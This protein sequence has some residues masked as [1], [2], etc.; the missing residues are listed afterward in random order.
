M[1]ASLWWLCLG[2][3]AIGTEGFMIAGLL[4]V[5]AADLGVSVPAA[6][7]LVTVFAITYAV[8]SP[9]MATL[10]GNVDRRRVLIGALA[11]AMRP[12]LHQ[13]I[14]W[15]LYTAQCATQNQQNLTL[16]PLVL[17]M[18]HEALEAL[19]QA[20]DTP[21]VLPYLP[22]LVRCMQTLLEG[23]D[24]AALT[25]ALLPLLV[26]F[27]RAEYAQALLPHVSEVVDVLIGWSLEATSTPSVA[28]KVALRG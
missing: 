21:C 16:W 14:S 3:F 27:S 7:Q 24:E 6:G 5:L 8:G 9:V 19:V 1:P 25:T 20:R 23:L 26:S 22:D 15:L 4:P 10:P 2:A 11:A 28:A 17:L 13:F 18:M 12:N